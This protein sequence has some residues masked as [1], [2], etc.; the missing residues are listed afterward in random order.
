M[1]MSFNLPEELQLLQKNLR[2]YVDTEMIPHER[3]A[4]VGN[5]LKPEWKARFEQGMKDLGVWMLDVPEEYGGAGLGLLAKSIVWTELG[6]TVA[7]PARGDHITGPSAR[8]ILYQLR[9]KMRER[10]LMPVLEGRKECCFAQTEPDAGSDPGSMRTTAVRDGDYYVING[11]KRF[12]TGA[13]KA[14]F[15]QLMV[16]TDRAKGSRGGISC[17]LIDM[18]TLGVK[19][20]AQYE[21]MMGDKPWEII[22]DNVRVHETQMVGK[23]GEGFKLAQGW[24]GH[25]RVKHGAR[26]LGVAERALQ[27]ATAYSHQRSTFG[28]PLADR[29]GIQWMLG[30]MYMNLDVGRLLVWRAASMIDEGQ[31]ARVE[32][33]HAKYFCDEMAFKA[34]DN[35][36]QIHGGIALTTDLPIE[37]MWR[38]QRSYRITEGASEVMRTVIARHVM[39]EY[40]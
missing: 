25:G 4:M 31:E 17:F 22:L 19:L 29:Q 6:R 32:A 28:R 18:N 16:A 23:E 11:T 35:C 2:R 26:A 37:R 14:D 12:I 38:Q 20:G 21:T 5:E 3:E 9:G 13:G 30:D 24:L 36:M 34:I 15:M 40:A 10:Y 8:G 39:K 1:T 27:L 33:Y 7:I